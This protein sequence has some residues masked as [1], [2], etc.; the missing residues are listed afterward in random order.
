MPSI[1]SIYAQKDKM[2]SIPQISLI[3]ASD[4]G[5]VQLLT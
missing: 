2:C 4:A 3:K 5:E 1:E